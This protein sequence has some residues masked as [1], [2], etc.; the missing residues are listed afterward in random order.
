L[1]LSA[2]RAFLRD[3]DPC[4]VELECQ[5]SDPP[6]HPFPSFSGSRERRTENGF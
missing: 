2:R 3:L 4:F 1:G 5:E 6:F